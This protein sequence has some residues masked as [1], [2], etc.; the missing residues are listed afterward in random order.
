MEIPVNGYMY[1][2][3]LYNLPKGIV[4]FEG[5]G[6]IISAADR[7]VTFEMRCFDTAWNP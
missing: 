2:N 3:R 5:K 1:F 7:K 4:V 6:G